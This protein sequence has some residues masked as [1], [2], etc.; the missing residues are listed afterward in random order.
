MELKHITK[1]FLALKAHEKVRIEQNNKFIPGR[2]KNL[3][4][5]FNMRHSIPQK[6]LTKIVMTVV[7]EKAT[8]DKVERS[9]LSVFPRPKR[10]FK[11]KKNSRTGTH[12]PNGKGR[13]QARKCIYFQASDD[14]NNFNIDSFFPARVPIDENFALLCKY[15]K[16]FAL[17]ELK[18]RS[19]LSF[20]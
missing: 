19:K 16:I 8:G 3:Q 5:T 9:F 1:G 14:D 2:R 15:R 13:K 7:T 18:T 11:V 10:K 17:S 4:L 6:S 20:F 12:F